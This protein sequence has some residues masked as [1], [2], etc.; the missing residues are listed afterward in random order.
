MW[1][2]SIE[3]IL[4]LIYHK[5]TMRMSVRMDAR[6]ILSNGVEGGVQHLKIDHF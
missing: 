1:I 5:D 3:G 2:H 4:A 6:T